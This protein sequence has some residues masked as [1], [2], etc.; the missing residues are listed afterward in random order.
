ME[1]TWP[2]PDKKHCKLGSTAAATNKVPSRLA[3]GWTAGQAGRQA[4]R[5]TGAGGGA[6]EDSQKKD[7]ARRDGE[8]DGDGGN[9]ALGIDG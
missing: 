8:G 4:G 5:Q 9:A 1:Q 2:G 6:G 3:L 7:T